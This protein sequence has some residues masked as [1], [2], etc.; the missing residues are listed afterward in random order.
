M[1]EDQ[2]VEILYVRTLEESKP[3]FLQQDT[4]N[5]AIENAG[6]IDDST[7]WIQRR[8]SYL[9]RTLPENIQ[10]YSLIPHRPNRFIAIVFIIVFLIGISA[11]FLA[12]GKYVHIIN[13]PIIILIVWNL[14]IFFSLILAYSCALLYRK[15]IHKT[16]PSLSHQ[17][18]QFTQPFKDSASKKELGIDSFQDIETRQAKKP[19]ILLVIFNKLFPSVYFKWKK[20]TGKAREQKTD[21]S[22][23]A[24]TYYRFWQ[25]YWDASYPLLRSRLKF[26]IHILAIALVMGAITGTYLR[27]LFTEYFFIWES[28]FIKSESLVRII[29]NV[30]LGLPSLIIDGSFITPKSV[31]QL[32]QGSP[33]S[34]WIKLVS[35]TA[36]IFVIV[37]RCM[38]CLIEIINIQRAKMNLKINVS[39]QYFQ[40]IISEAYESRIKKLGEDVTGIVKIEISKFSEAVAVFVKEK[41]YDSKIVP[42]L[43][44]FR[45]TGG[46]IN[47]LIH[48]IE[49]S[50]ENFE[51]EIQ[52]YI[53]IA[54]NDLQASL[55]I[56]IEKL[57]GKKLPILNLELKGDFNKPKASE[58]DVVGKSMAQDLTNAISITVTTAV[59]GSIAKVSGG[60]GS[61]LGIAIVVTLF[62]TTGPV[63]WIIG[64]VAGLVVGG[65]ISWLAKDKITETIKNQKLP[66][67]MTKQLLSE[68]T[69]NKR[70]D[71]GR[72]K[73]INDVK[74]EVENELQQSAPEIADSI[75]SEIIKALKYRTRKFQ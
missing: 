70:I 56:Q 19:S 28:T 31:Q 29:L 71:E 52:K 68:A 48:E 63:G 46:R 65:G 61:K 62:G 37:P 42:K 40:T 30:F 8:A 12:P 74:T 55:A 57:I 17:D 47:D 43:N 6:E 72:Q 10:I 1:T 69:L 36:L 73:L 21:L 5:K 67:L 51:N 66:S 11:N 35:L 15:K 7:E 45:N 26:A 41:L 58:V 16:T 24:K 38:L 3:D 23:S 54:K 64:A 27:G 14:F 9:F 13:N 53:K 32:I 18:R 49:G 22:I 50:C 59:A 39:D 75:I 20:W 2:A 25:Y 34:Y 33:A 60:F 44:G 4:L